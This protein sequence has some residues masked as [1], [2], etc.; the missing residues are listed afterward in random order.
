MMPDIT[1]TDKYIVDGQGATMG[2]HKFYDTILMTNE[3][4]KNHVVRIPLYDIFLKYR[5]HFQ[6][7]IQLYQM[8]RS[9]FYKPKSLSLELYGTTEMWLALLRLNSM[10]NITEFKKQVIKIYNPDVI[11]ELIDIFFKREGKIT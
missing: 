6:E 1:F 8:P 11:T 10:R 5:D 4:N 2:L 7:S 3:N 9:L